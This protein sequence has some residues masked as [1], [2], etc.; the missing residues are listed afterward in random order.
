MEKYSAYRDAGTGIQPFLNPVPPTVS[1]LLATAL[2]PFRYIIGALRIVLLL[3]VGILYLFLTEVVLYVFYPVPPLHKFIS[4]AFTAVSARLALLVLGLWWIPVTYVAR[5]RGRSV[6]MKEPWKPKAGDII[7]SNWASWVEVLWLAFRFN[8]IFVLPS[9]VPV[10][11]YSAR[12]NISQSNV[13]GRRTGTGSAAISSSVSRPPAVRVPIQGFHTVSLL[14]MICSTGL[15]PPFKGLVGDARPLKSIRKDAT[16]PVVVFPEC[17]TSN[18]R[19]LL[20]FAQVFDESV[21]VKAFKV[22]VMCVRYDPP[23]LYTPTLTC[24]I[25]S[26]SAFNPLAHLFHVASSLSLAL[27]QSLSIRLLYPAE[28]P[29][30]GSFLASDILAAGGYKD[31]LTEACS[32]LIGQLGKMRITGQ[33]WEDKFAFLEFYR[34]KANR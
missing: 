8:P 19:A 13:T 22:F 25:P 30:S 21:P 26:Y 2:L 17:T 27:P 33:A 5:R 15:V 4:W 31:D 20:R 29:S 28:S 18:G 14:K 12:A 34:A 10:D 1:S 32:V 7:V 24:S 3:L 9:P 23:T 6:P 16:R 11:Q